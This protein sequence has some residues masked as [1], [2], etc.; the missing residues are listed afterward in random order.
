MRPGTP[1]YVVTTE[2]AITWGRHFYAS[3]SIQD[4]VLGVV[5]TFVMDYGLT[6]ALHDKSRTLLRRIMAMWSE[7]LC[8]R[9]EEPG[10]TYT[11]SSFLYA[12]A[13]CQA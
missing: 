8:Y 9:L 4:T 10:K 1:H 13:D 6:N 11:Y 2:D 5:Q 7:S 3:S 12:N